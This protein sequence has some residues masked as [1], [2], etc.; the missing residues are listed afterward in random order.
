M[1]KTTVSKAKKIKCPVCHKRYV[2]KEAVYTHI[3]S[4]HADMIPEGMPADQYYYDLTHDN[5]K[6]LCV[7]CKKETPWNPKTH[8]YHRLCGSAECAKK[9]REIFKAR[10]KRVYKKY[11]LANDPEHQKKMLA[12]RKI[13]G[14]YQ[15]SSGGEPTVYVGSYEK[16]F[17]KTCDLILNFESSDIIAP[18][19]NIYKYIYKGKEHFYMPD[20]YF[21][22]LKLE[23]EI[24]DGGDNPNR[25]PKIVKVDKEKTR[26]KD[27]VLLSQRDNHYIKIV[28]KVYDSFFDL[29]PKLRSDEL[30]DEERRNKIKIKP[31]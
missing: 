17:L 10:M 31:E 29:I 23:I 11:N 25:H 12:A 26:L 13:S 22:E 24:K 16:D 28:N 6:T 15:W 27:E 7:I 21:P 1:A 14:K 4:Q 30:T 5:K 3:E 8:K 20:F 19:P 18:S 2:S 9:N